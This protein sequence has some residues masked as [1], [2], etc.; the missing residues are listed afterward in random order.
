[1]ECFPELEYEINRNQGGAIDLWSDLYDAL[2]AAYREHPTNETLIR[3]IYDYAAWCFQQPTTG[4]PDTDLSNATAVGLIESLPLD[5]RVSDDL[6]RW[7]SVE[8]F[9]GCERL[10][11]YHL[12]EEQYRKFQADFL[13][14][15]RGYSGPSRL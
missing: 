7:F 2:T 8:T 10:F 13:A 9:E 3:R 14:K 15:K 1:L 11:R 12:S 6:Y 4:N 5:Q